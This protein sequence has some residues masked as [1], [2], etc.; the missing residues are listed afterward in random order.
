M[1][2][3]EENYL[4]AIYKISHIEGKKEV[5]TNALAEQMQTKASSVTDMLK[6]LAEKDL[7]NYEKYKGFSLTK[8]GEKVALFTIRKHRLWEVFLVDHLNFT[9]DE[10]HEVAE[11]LEHIN[12]EKLI[13]NLDEFLGFPETDPHGDPIPN[14]SGTINHHKEFVL[15]DLKA[16]EKGLIIG[17]KEHS[18]SF[19]KYLDS[20]SIKLG[21]EIEMDNLFEFDG[22]V[23]VTY[24]GMVKTL[25]Q[26]VSKNL[27]IKRIEN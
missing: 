6:K 10:V 9:W 15:K 20:Q 27:Y 11:E 26:M 25:S 22:S 19:L 12:S 17:V 2:F 8:K 1:T 4:K 3:T 13:N 23:V 21:T 5:N 16:G 7:V 18:P 24:D 14:K